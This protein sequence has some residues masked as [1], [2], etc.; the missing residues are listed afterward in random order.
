MADAGL[1]TPSLPTMV[2]L[3]ALSLL[4]IPRDER[5]MWVSKK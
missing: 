2:S 4:V 3:L 5:P 1:F